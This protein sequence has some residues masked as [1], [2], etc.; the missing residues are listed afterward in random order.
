MNTQV[1]VLV[2][3]AIVVVGV[4]TAWYMQKRRHAHLRARFGPE[5]ER[6]VRET[7]NIS[8]AESILAHRERRVDK[9]QLRPLTRE[10]SRRFSDTWRG[11]QSQFVDDPNRAFLDA[12]RLITE[13]MTTR[14]YPMSDWNQ[15]VADISVDYPRVCD[16]YRAGHDIAIRN[17]RGEASTEDLRR[18]MVEYRALFTELAGADEAANHRRQRRAG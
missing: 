3:I 8:K 16:R 18:G 14:G 15:R 4:G 10:E 9:L 12:D 7:G 2:L 6:T 11:V 1:L 17:E 5:Y 13:V